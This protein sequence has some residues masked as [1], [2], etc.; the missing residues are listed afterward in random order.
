VFVVRHAAVSANRANRL[1]HSLSQGSDASSP[2]SDPISA[3]ATG[4][5]TSGQDQPAGSA[6]AA[7]P[8]AAGK[9]LLTPE[10]VRGVIAKILKVSGGTKVVKMVVYDDHASF[11]VVKKDD[12]GVYDTYIYINGQAKFQMTGDTLDQGE[13]ALDPT[14]INWDALPTMIKDANGSLNVK[15]PKYRYVVV[16]SDIITHVPEMM[17]YLADDYRGGYIAADLKGDVT[18]RM[19]AS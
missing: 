14:K 19:P 6:S 3:P 7:D 13:P 9:S 18:R 2:G 11:D 8:P 10:G 17:F 4:I 5:N 16:D 15:K 1:N 12:P